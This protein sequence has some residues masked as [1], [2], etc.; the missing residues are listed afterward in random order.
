MRQAFAGMLWSKQYYGY[1]VARWLDGDPG[2]P[3]PPPERRHGPQRRMATLRRGRHP[4]D[5][6]PVGVPVVRRLGSRLPRGHPRPHRSGVRQVPAAAAVPRMVPAPERRAARLRVVVRRR[7]P[8]RPRRGG[9]PRLGHRRAARH[10]FP[11]ADLPQAADQLHLVAE[12]RG[13]G[14]QRPVLGRLPRARQHRRLRP[15]APAGR[16]RARA[17]RRDGLDVHVLPLDAADRDRPGRDDPAYEDFE[18][19]FL[20]HA[21]RIARGDEPERPVGSRGRVLLRRAQARRRLGRPDQGPFDGRA[22]PAPAVRGR[23]G[24]DRR[25]RSA[26]REAVR[27]VPRRDARHR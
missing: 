1:N 20:E 21:V 5:A 14:G 15:V 11:Q 8:A 25:P 23:P 24:H 17:V 19:S 27:A 18:T 10:R 3:P 26:P 4:V 6:R 16:H 22:H 7:Q 13:Q 12:P 2:L 9:L